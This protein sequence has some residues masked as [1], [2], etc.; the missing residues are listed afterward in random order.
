EWRAGVLLMEATQCLFSRAQAFVLVLSREKSLRDPGRSKGADQ[1]L[2]RE[3]LFVKP[4]LEVSLDRLVHRAAVHHAVMR[5]QGDPKDVDVSVLERTRAIVVHLPERKTKGFLTWPTRVG[6]RDHPMGYRRGARLMAGQGLEAP[7][8]P[9]H[10][11]WRR[12]VEGLH[13]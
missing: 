5:Q 7:A 6:R 10:R 13:H 2:F 12:Q 1:V 9:G 8:A 3:S 4:R 11:R